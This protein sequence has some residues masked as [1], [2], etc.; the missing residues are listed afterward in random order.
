M[1]KSGKDLSSTC[2]TSMELEVV[3]RI[4]E[5]CLL[6]RPMCGTTA[7]LSSLTINSNHLSSEQFDP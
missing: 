5:V 1:W 3:W 6:F 4:L 2:Q 7:H